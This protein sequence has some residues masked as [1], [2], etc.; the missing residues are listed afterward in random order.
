MPYAFTD[1]TRYPYQTGKL[2]LGLNGSD[3]IGVKL[4]RGATVIAPPRTGK[5]VG[6]IIPNLVRWPH[7]SLTIDPSGG[8]VRATWKALEEERDLVSGE[9]KKQV[10]VLDPFKVADIPDRLRV[11]CNILDAIDADSPTFREDCRVVA[12]GNVIRYKSSDG[13]WDNGA[14]TFIAGVIGYVCATMKG[15]DRTLLTVR[16]LL[17]LPNA[18]DADGKSP[19]RELCLDMTGMGGFI[20]EAGN[21]GLSPAKKMQDYVG[22]AIESTGWIDKSMSGVLAASS[23]RLSDL[24]KQ[25][26]ALFLVIPE[27]YL[28]DHSRFLRL[29][30]RFALREMQAAG[31]GGM[32]CLFILDEFYSL[33]RIDKLLKDAT[34][35]PKYGVHIMPIMHNLGQLVE[36][37]GPQGAQTFFSA[38]DADIFFGS[39]DHETLQ[40]ISNMIGMPSPAD[41]VDGPPVT[42]IV[43]PQYVPSRHVEALVYDP[44]PY[45]DAASYRQDGFPV[46]RLQTPKFLGPGPSLFEGEKEWQHR[47]EIEDENFRRRFEMQEFNARR[48]VEEIN[49]NDRRQIDTENQRRRA[50]IDAENENRRRINDIENENR[51]RAV[52]FEDESRRRA[53]AAEDADRRAVYEHRMKLLS[54]PS[55]M[56]KEIASLIGARES[57]KVARSMIVFLNGGDVLNLSLAPDYRNASEEERRRVKHEARR[58]E[59]V[60]AL[61]RG[62]FG[63]L[64]TIF[65]L[66]KDKIYD[67][68]G[69][70]MTELHGRINLDDEFDKDCRYEMP[71]DDYLE[72]SAVSHQLASFLRENPEF[73]RPC[74]DKNCGLREPAA[75]KKTAR[76]RP[77]KKPAEKPATLPVARKP[78]TAR[79]AAL[80]AI[81]ARKPAVWSFIQRVLMPRKN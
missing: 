30:V 39:R 27:T 69:L 60:D 42:T 9:N 50:L 55:L 14:V 15:A 10:A 18:P 51:R 61:M 63:Q 7:S 68:A 25:R 32:P 76:K 41:L 3:H 64:K 81:P 13:M 36:L 59:R 6:F 21:I 37:Y 77:A 67:A 44:L 73:R 46:K 75:P 34:S 58:K 80:P 54:Q 23:F 66:P 72:Q 62:D 56:P 53:A 12:D 79:H 35:L 24:K 22:G 4:K 16:E 28:D 49:E 26:T 5:G 57:D 47:V 74:R 45:A 31:E 8:N 70:R 1:P 71:A 17:I 43:P 40:H 2:F 11:S 65:D 29:F 33:G 48:A 20:A 19:F 52:E 38:S 78:G